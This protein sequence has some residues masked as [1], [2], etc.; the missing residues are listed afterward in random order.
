M[1]TCTYFPLI[2]F[3]VY[4]HSWSGFY[5]WWFSIFSYRFNVFLSRRTCR[6]ALPHA[7]Y[8]KKFTKVYV[9]L[10]F[11]N[12]IHFVYAI[13]FPRLSSNTSLAKTS[14]PRI[15]HLMYAVLDC[16]QF[17]ETFSFARLTGP[18]WVCFI[19]I[20]LCSYP[21]SGLNLMH[22]SFSINYCPFRHF[23]AN[24]TILWPF[25]IQWTVLRSTNWAWLR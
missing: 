3:W 1:D 2:L 24:M 15:F 25:M 17:S 6:P 8:G 20:L 11:V 5:E 18:V 21:S 10:F 14:M 22:L 23:S 9:N 4:P 16:A 13:C 19:G 12:I 7:W